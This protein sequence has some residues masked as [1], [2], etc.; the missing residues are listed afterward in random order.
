M[1][2][3]SNRIYGNYYDK[4]GSKNIIEK[5]LVKRYQ[6]NLKELLSSVTPESILDV[7][8]GEGFITD[9]LYRVTGNERIFGLEFGKEILLKAEKDYP[10]ISFKH[11]SAY[12]I[13]FGD[14]SFDL[15]AALELL[16]HL[17]EP[18]RALKEIKR[19]TKKWFLL[20]IPLEP[21]WSIMNIVRFKYLKSFGNTPG[22]VNK[23]SLKG[24]QQMLEKDFEIIKIQR[25]LPW[26]M[27]LCR[28]RKF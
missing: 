15:V 24:C 11:G 17:D 26:I 25:P 14:N 13:P 4:Y 8:C 2:I 7:G 10:H 5:Y 20:S 23:W 3:D 21:L 27:I 28:T 1:N 22:H 9:Q 19:V 6:R 12:D 16:E 18:A